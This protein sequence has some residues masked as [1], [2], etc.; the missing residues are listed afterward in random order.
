MVL[1]KKV[2]FYSQARCR[3][4]LDLPIHFGPPTCPTWAILS[5]PQIFRFLS[6]FT[7]VISSTHSRRHAS[8]MLLNTG[9]FI[10]SRIYAIGGYKYLLSLR[11]RVDVILTRPLIL[12]CLKSTTHVVEQRTSHPELPMEAWPLT[13]SSAFISRQRCVEYNDRYVIPLALMVFLLFVVARV[14]KLKHGLDA[15]NHLPGPWI[16]FQPLDFPGSI[17]PTTWWN[18]GLCWSWKWRFTC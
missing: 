14:K 17:L 7:S 1:E 9:S 16:P 5:I 12:F 13:S 8:I 11:F 18:P 10:Y 4:G 2:K 15:V 6:V 3:L